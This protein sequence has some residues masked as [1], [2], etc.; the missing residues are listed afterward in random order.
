LYSYEIEK[1]NVFT[2]RG[3]RLFLGIRDQ[4]HRLLD[5]SGAVR[6][7]EAMALPPGIGAA[8]SWEML[9]CVDRL[10]ELGEI[11]EVTS[12]NVAGQD[13]VFVAKETR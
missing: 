6:M 4:V 8:S 11:R 12:G 10:V 9:A 7:Q 5:L 1:P 3:Q 2:E 13:R